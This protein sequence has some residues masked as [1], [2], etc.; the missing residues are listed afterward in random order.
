MVACN[1]V[2]AVVGGICGARAAAWEA[3]R[4]LRDKVPKHGRRL[5]GE[6]NVAELIVPLGVAESVRTCA[7]RCGDAKDC[8]RGHEH[9]L[10]AQ[11]VWPPLGRT[12][13]SPTCIL[14]AWLIMV[15]R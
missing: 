8:H 11:V 14:M 6:C 2:T 15:N 7:T 13:C 9:L 12:A 4:R 3:V 5:Q 1:D 10:S